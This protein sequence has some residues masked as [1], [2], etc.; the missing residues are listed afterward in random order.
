MENSISAARIAN[1][2]MQDK[3][4]EGAYLLVEGKKDIR[5]YKKFI[6]KQNCKLKPTFG[7]YKMRDVYAILTSRN[8]EKK[9]GVRDAD[10]LRLKNN[11]KFNPSY[12]ENIFPTDFHDSEGMI[13]NSNAFYEF[14]G[15]FVETEKIQNFESKYG[16]FRELVYDLCYAIGCLR[17]AN[18][19]YSLGLSFKPEKPEGNRIKYKK[20]ICEKEIKY[21]G[22]EKLINT[23]TEYSKNRGNEIYSKEEIMKSLATILNE[24]QEKTEIVNGHDLS[25][26]IYI[27]LKQGLKSTSKTLQSAESIEELLCLSF[28]Y[29]HFS[30]TYLYNSLMKWQELNGETIFKPAQQAA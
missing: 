19:R 9:V 16:N 5:L 21:L 15:T 2:I 7:K 23:L 10:F 8:F 25:Q 6:D 11:E 3:S 28:H 12:S 20:I 4:F 26:A 1:S 14:I 18:K 17:L 29:D 30:S 24:K 22:D 27:V 13:V